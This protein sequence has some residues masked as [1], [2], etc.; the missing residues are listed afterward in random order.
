[1]SLSGRLVAVLAVAAALW[2][3]AAL[4]Q[5]S[6]VELVQAR[7]ILICG[8]TGPEPGFSFREEGEIVGFDAD[9]CRA[10]AAWLDVDVDFNFISDENRVAAVEA[11]AVDVIVRTTAATIAVGSEVEFGPAVFHDQQRLLVR[12]DSGVAR[13]DDLAGDV[14]CVQRGGPAEANLMEA[15]RVQELRSAVLAYEEVTQAFL[16]LMSGRCAALSAESSKLGALRALAPDPAVFIL[17]GEA[18]SIGPLAPLYRPGDSE[19]SRVVNSTIW[20]LIRAEEL[21]VT[22]ADA[23]EPGRL[24]AAAEGEEALRDLIETGRDALVRVLAIVGNYGELYDRWFGPESAVPIQ[25]EG[26]PNALARDGGA[27]MSWPLR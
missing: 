8:V 11:G 24:E 10:I 27:M 15:L 14:I 3:A 13:L 6:R 26:T 21:G 19:W 2:P 23:R 20:G 22:G 5:Q 7:G 18:L 12:G 17:S 4:A 1:M 25:R 16:A 9:L